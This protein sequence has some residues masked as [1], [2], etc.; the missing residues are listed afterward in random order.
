MRRIVLALLATAAFGLVGASSAL[1]APVNGAAVAQLGLEVDG[2]IQVR[3]GCGRNAHREGG[4][5]VRGCGEG[6]YFS[7]RR[8]HCIH[9]ERPVPGGSGG[10]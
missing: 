2:V 4:H 1:A 9:G 5:C 7:P 3:D 10:N 8:R 6:W